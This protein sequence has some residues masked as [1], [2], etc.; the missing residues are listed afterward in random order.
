MPRHAGK[1]VDAL[2]NAFLTRATKAL[3]QIAQRLDAAALERAVAA[4]TDAG[5]LARAVSEA[6][7]YGEA[8]GTLDPLAELIAR[9]GEQKLELLK[10]AGGTLTVSEVA[11]VLRLT[12]QGIDKRRQEHKLVAV[13]RGAEYAFPACQ[14]DDD[15]VVPDLPAILKILGDQGWIA[16]AFLLSEFDELNG[17]TPLEV[18]RRKDRTLKEP[19]ERLARITSGDGIG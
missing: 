12:R 19:L 18:L 13:R 4:P 7:A 16:L 9:G 11:R 17:S 6:A 5:A 15:G 10:Q 1:A 8:E 3:D 2:H 14:F